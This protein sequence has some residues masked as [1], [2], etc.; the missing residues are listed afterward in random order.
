MRTR[1]PESRQTDADVNDNVQIISLIVDVFE[2]LELALKI[3][4][5]SV[6]PLDL[7][8]MTQEVFSNSPSGTIF[9]ILPSL[10]L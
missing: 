10:G 4:S 9:A 7:A 5:T 1:W 6:F 3:T 2:I 8:L